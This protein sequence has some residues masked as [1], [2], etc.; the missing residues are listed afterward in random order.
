MVDCCVFS[1]KLDKNIDRIEPISD[2]EFL[3]ASYHLDQV[4]KSG[5]LNVIEVKDNQIHVKKQ[6]EQFDF[7]ILSV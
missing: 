1:L 4:T 7:G 3:V 2:S 6:L 5:D